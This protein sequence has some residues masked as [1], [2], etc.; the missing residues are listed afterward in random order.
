MIPS[1]PAP[2]FMSEQDTARRSP[3][4]RALSLVGSLRNSRRMD[5]H[6][7]RSCMH[8]RLASQRTFVL[9]S[10][11]ILGQLQ[12]PTVINTA[13]QSRS[14]ITVTSRHSDTSLMAILWSSR[15]RHIF[16]NSG[17]V[18]TLTDHRQAI[19]L[20][21]YRLFLCSWDFILTLCSLLYGLKDFTFNLSG[22]T[23]EK[24]YRNYC[25]TE[26]WGWPHLF[27]IFQ[28][29]HVSLVEIP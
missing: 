12:Y 15:M 6:E 13:K 27:L 4:A 1:W 5:C 11:F 10:V 18:P 21:K 29:L 26:P 14:L 9:H 19:G 17:I 28:Y 23:A 16:S 20:Q 3:H 25:T 8:R 7:E 24:W 2:A 22:F